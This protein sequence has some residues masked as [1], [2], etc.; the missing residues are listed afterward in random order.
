MLGALSRIGGVQ[1]QVM[2]AAEMGLSAR[3]DGLAAEDVRDAL[4][5]ERTLLKTWAMRATLHL[6]SA[7]DLPLYT[8]ARSLYDT[9]NF[10]YYFQYHGIS[11]KDYETLLAA[12]PEILGD[13]PL[14]R[15]Q[16]AAALGKRT[17]SSELIK[18]IQDKG[19]GTPLKPSAWRGDLCFGPSQGRNVAFVNPRRWINDWQPLEPYPAL[20][21]VAR[22][23][24]RAYGPAEADDFARWWELRLRPARKLF[25]TLSNV[26][27][28]VDVEGWRAFVLRETLEPMRKMPSR[29]EVNL[30]P[31]FDIYLMGLRRGQELDPLLPLAHQ[32]QVFHPQGWISAVVLVDGFIRGVWEYQSRRGQIALKVHL[33]EPPAA[34][35]KKGILAEA[36]RLSGFLGSKVVVEYVERLSSSGPQ[37]DIMDE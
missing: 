13:Q 18:L 14:T 5:K 22:R 35:I 23:Y 2:S 6:I 36:E 28:E 27:E 25:K 11:Q 19:W 33:F 8:A 24:L 20:Q 26:L 7:A 1:A 21:E 34:E 17:G 10:P 4:W 30:L 9:R 12:V 29:G 32:G 37:E 3:V 15:E 31:M 16:L